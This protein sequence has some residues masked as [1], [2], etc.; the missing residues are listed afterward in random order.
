MP[1]ENINKWTQKGHVYL[2][3]YQENTRNYPGWH[4]TADETFCSSFAELIGRMLVAQYGSR[5]SLAVTAPTKE[6][7]S[8]PNNRGGAAKW[9][10]PKALILKHRKDHITD[11]YFS[12]EE[13]EDAII[14]S[15][16]RQKLE[17]LKDCVLNIPKNQD[18]SI[19][20]GNTQ[21]W[22]W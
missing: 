11:D 4:L 7:L 10:S 22:F 13:S 16:G 17:L 3:R 1:D 2:W 5:Q 6:I 12:L 19:E 9:K 14:I 20:I 8:I 21:L 15:A 18:Y